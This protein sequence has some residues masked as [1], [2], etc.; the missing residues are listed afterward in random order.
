[1]FR[2]LDEAP[3]HV[4]IP[5]GHIAWAA[6]TTVAGA[7]RACPLLSGCPRGGFTLATTRLP[8]AALVADG[9]TLYWITR[10]NRD[11]S[12]PRAADDGGARTPL[13]GELA[14]VVLRGD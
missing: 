14:T 13:V 6:S 5:G 11:A 1:M 2:E 12:D 4:A 10:P 3:S 9:A 7:V 8:V